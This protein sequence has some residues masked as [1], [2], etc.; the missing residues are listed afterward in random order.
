MK[1][2]KY[3]SLSVYPKITCKSM[4]W[5]IEGVYFTNSFWEGGLF[6]R[7]VF[8]RPYGKPTSKKLRENLI[9]VIKCPMSQKF[10]I[11]ILLFIENPKK[12]GLVLLKSDNFDGTWRMCV[13]F[14]ECQ[15]VISNSSIYLSCQKKY[16]CLEKK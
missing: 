15:P 9:F 10:Q 1:H 14:L 3:V 4:N 6:K 2:P 13:S 16:P 8:S 5:T 12:T 11:I 7:E